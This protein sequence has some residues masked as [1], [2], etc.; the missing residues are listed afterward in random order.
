MN[1]SSMVTSEYGAQDAFTVQLSSR[2][3]HPVI[4]I[5]TSSNTAEVVVA[6]TSLTFQPSEWNSPKTVYVTGQDELIDDGDSLNTI[7]MQPV[8]F[9]SNYNNLT[10]SVNVTN[11][12]NDVAGLHF[13]VRAWVS[14]RKGS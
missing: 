8:S 9:D 3:L 2:P 7:T 14:K 5:L 4:V 10:F 12:D 6:P 13:C 1:A 11:V